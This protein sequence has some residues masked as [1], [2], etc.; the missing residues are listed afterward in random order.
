MT[1]KSIPF[2]P[3]PLHELGE[4][5]LRLKERLGLISLIDEGTRMKSPESPIVADLF[6]NLWE[7]VN[8][9]VSGSR[10]NRLKP[11]ASHNGFRIIE[12]NAETGE[13]LG[14]LNMLYLRKPMPCYYLVYV[15]VAAPFRRKGLGTR[16]LKH[17]REFL[18]SRSAVGILDNII[19][20]DDPTYDIYLRQS[21]KPIEDLV[22]DTA[23]AD[24]RY[25]MIY[26]PPGMEGKNLKGPVLKLLHHLN[27][28]RAAID[29]RDNQIMVQR[30]IEEFKGLHSALTTYFQDEIGQNESSPLM[31]FMFTRFVTKLIAFR[32]RIENLVGYT[33]GD[34]LEQISLSPEIARLPAQS[35]APLELENGPALVEGDMTF[36][37]QLPEPFRKHPAGFI[38]GLPNYERPS[39]TAWMEE[40]GIEKGH[41]LTIGNLMDLGFDPTRLK[42]M[43]V[44]GQPCIIER[45]QAKQLPELK[46]KEGLLKEIQSKMSGCRIRNASLKVNLPLLTIRDRGNAYIL[47][48]KIRG[49]HYE[50]AMEQIQSI[51]CL[52]RLDGELRLQRMI[53][54]TVREAYGVIAAQLHV[55]EELL[56]DR[57]ACFV[58]WDIRT[59]RPV[60]MVDF[61]N[62]YLAAVWMA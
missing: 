48:R 20:E 38:E 25:Y 28:K 32:R 8:Q 44:N 22:G 23:L 62:S 55:A 57:M 4:R 17:F 24:K 54:G 61:T 12:V 21:W 50:E 45:I 43:E 51:P 6:N 26:I 42:E 47:R 40:A 33:G 49:I 15:E 9:T 59:N 41:R 5:D 35:Y 30:T 60:M 27:R 13:N 3:Y 19:P 1:N 53:G 37:N 36:W 16:I 56:S 14:R 2:S 58:P 46:Q 7:L 18:A 29:M 34:S 31:R 52:R 10:I 39:L 11:E